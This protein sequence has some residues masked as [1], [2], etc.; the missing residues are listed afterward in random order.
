[1]SWTG[2]RSHDAGLDA[3][4]RSSADDFLA[5]PADAIEARHVVIADADHRRA[6]VGRTLSHY[7][8]LSQL[9]AGAMGVYKAGDVANAL[10]FLE[11]ALTERDAYVTFLGTDPKWDGLRAL[12]A[13]QEIFARAQLLDVSRHVAARAV[14]A[15]PTRP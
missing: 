8:I 11:Q 15:G 13:F 12:P 2:R 7:R 14:P 4:I 1:V 6:F 3:E 5:A 10:S 9:G